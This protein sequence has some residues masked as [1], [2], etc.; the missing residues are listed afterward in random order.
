MVLPIKSIIKILDYP[1]PQGPNVKYFIVVDCENDKVFTLLAMTTTN[2]SQFYFNLNDI[3][4][5]HGAIKNNKGEIF[6]Y[7]FPSGFT[8]GKAGF[9]FPE[10]TFLLSEHCFRGH[11][12]EDMYRLKVEL[13]DELT[14]DEFRNLIYSF[15]KS[16]SVKNKYLPT[17]EKVLNI[18]N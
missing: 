5:K 17:L 10:H 3:E 1:L 18:E 2:K 7:C 13:V 9:S 11:S 4:I 14:D 8:I 15:Y 12:C 16:P 6:M